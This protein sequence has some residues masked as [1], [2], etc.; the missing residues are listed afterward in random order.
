MSISETKVRE[1]LN[2]PLEYDD[3][4]IQGLGMLRL[5]LTPDGSERLHIWDPQRALNE[6]P[7][8]HNHPWDIVESRVYFGQMGNQRYA[9]SENGNLPMTASDVNCGVGSHLMGEPRPVAIA[10][11][12]DFEV[13][14]PGEHYAMDAE[15]FHNS[16]PVTGT[17]TIMKRNFKENRHLATICWAG[18]EEWK[19]A[20]FTREATRGEI[21]SFTGLVALT[22]CVDL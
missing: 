17:V 10:E 8:V 20:N 21:L 5:P 12:S 19:Q 18:D 2:H 13:Y 14:E 11:V 16:F 7:S 4:V 1:I 3:W 9:I 22:T 6:Q 15:E